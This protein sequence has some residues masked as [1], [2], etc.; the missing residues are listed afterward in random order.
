MK[1]KKSL[2]NKRL[3]DKKEFR[4]DIGHI[5]D[6]DALRRDV[7]GLNTD[8]PDLGAQVLKQPLSASLTR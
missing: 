4:K 8:V 2:V 6:S 5:A 1:D 3:R 7:V